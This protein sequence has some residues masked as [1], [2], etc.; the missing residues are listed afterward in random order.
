MPLIFKKDLLDILVAKFSS[1][2]TILLSS[3]VS[4]LRLLDIL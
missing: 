3:Q 1:K 2:F 4:Y